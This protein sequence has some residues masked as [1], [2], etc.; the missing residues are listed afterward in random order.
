MNKKYRYL[1]GID[2]SIHNIYWRLTC[3]S[4]Y[5]NLEYCKS[6]EI[7]WDKYI[8]EQKT[9]SECI[10][11]IM[12]T[13]QTQKSQFYWI[14]KSE[15]TLILSIQLDSKI[16]CY[17]C[18][19]CHS[20]SSAWYR[21]LIDTKPC[22]SFCCL[23]GPLKLIIEFIHQLLNLYFSSSHVYGTQTYTCTHIDTQDAMVKPSQ[24][25]KP[26]GGGPVLFL[27]SV[28]ISKWNSHVINFSLLL[29]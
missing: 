21:I 9:P 7:I 26:C 25:E 24:R 4:Q 11:F 1:W 22:F 18:V 13:T 17:S 5:S 10:I 15:P 16:L 12:L 6:L 29:S 23:L 28:N 3:K 8:W 27:R 14:H 20:V 2:G 19:L